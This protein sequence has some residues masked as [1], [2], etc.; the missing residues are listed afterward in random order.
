MLSDRIRTMG[1]P[2]WLALFAM[3]LLAWGAL[4]VMA[5]TGDMAAMPG[6]MG[7]MSGG[8]DIGWPGMFGMWVLMSAAMMAPTVLPALATYDDL[9]R[10]GT[11][12]NMARLIGGYLTVWI[13]FSL[14]ASGAQMA[15]FRAD[16]LDQ[17][18]QS[19]SGWLSAMLLAG[20]GAY[21][22]LP[23]KEACLS[24]CRAP[25][26]FFMSHWDEGPWRNGL[27]LG[28]V[29]VGCCWALMAL[30]FVGGVMNLWFMGLATLVMIIEKLPEV[31]RWVTRPLGALLI[32]AA[33]M[34]GFGLI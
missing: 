20:A 17:M 34:V 7:T 2:H 13:G 5:T 15:L 25:L 11:A 26:T 8:A 33:G 24:K 16:L 10:T 21:Q 31:G 1:A 3:I 32:G 12:T 29:C 14:L 19:A 6:D 22:F 18:G 30:G 23:T 27:R 9:A 4:F 28:V